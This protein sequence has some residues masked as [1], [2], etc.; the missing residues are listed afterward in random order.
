M[1]L[2]DSPEEAAFR[3]GMRAFLDEHAHLYPSAAT[4]LPRG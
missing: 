4:G 2:N 1:D 3:A